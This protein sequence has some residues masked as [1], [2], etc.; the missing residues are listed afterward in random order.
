MTSSSCVSRA[1]TRTDSVFSGARRI[2]AP[3][4]T[5]L[6]LVQSQVG[7]SPALNRAPNPPPGE[8]FGDPA[9][10][11]SGVRLSRRRRGFPRPAAASGAGDRHDPRA[12]R[13]EPGEGQLG[14]RAPFSAAIARSRSGSR[15]WSKRLGLRSAAWWRKSP[16]RPRC[17]VTARSGNRG[18]AGCK[19]RSRCPARRTRQHSSSTSRPQG[20]LGLHR[21]H[22]LHGVGPAEGVRRRARTGRSA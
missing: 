7:M 8:D 3:P 22:R 13:E 18:R 20:V 5:G 19:A 10:R 17:P 2:R 15:L 4:L 16:G 6:F 12:L 14:E 11:S 1:R 9:A 21:R